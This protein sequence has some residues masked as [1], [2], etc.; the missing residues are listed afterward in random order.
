MPNSK[1]KV[2]TPEMLNAIREDQ[3]ESYQNAV[4]VATPYNLQEV[5]NPILTYEAVG[6][7]FVNDLVNKIVFQI[8]NRRMWQSPLAGLRGQNMPLGTTVEETHTNPSKAQ[9]YDGTE[10]GMAELLKMYKPDIATAYYTLNRQDKY[11]VTIN[12]DQLRGAFT[13]W[14]KMESLIASIVDS[15]YNGCTIDEYNYTKDLV[16]QAVAQGKVITQNIVMPIDRATGMQFLKTLRNMSV[17]FTFPSSNYNSYALL[18]GTPARTTWCPIDEQILLVRADVATEVGVE[19]LADI[20]HLDYA[21]YLTRQI[22][23]DNFNDDETLACLCDKKAF[24]IMEQLRQFRTFY[25]GSSLNW[26]YF[27]HA[28]DTF[29][30]SPFANMVVFKKQ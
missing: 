11:P 13:S 29:S 16:S 27:Y 7:A 6:N 17:L 8:I 21:D 14:D 2:A 4:P 10:T 30:L 15:L 5:G 23:V 3:T 12:N 25:N 1:E 26:Q 22:V 19:V 20:F 9:P 28:W 24:V 18:G